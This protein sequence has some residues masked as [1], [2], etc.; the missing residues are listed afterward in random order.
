MKKTDNNVNIL[1][2][3]AFIGVIL[4]ALL[5]IF[6]LS[7]VRDL[8]SLGPTLEHLLNT[9]KNVCIMLVIGFTAYNFV[10]GKGKGWLIIYIIAMSIILIATILA[11][12]V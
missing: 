10:K 5:E 7:F 4:V 1:N 3:M 12:I 11:W 9:V 8:I 6:S 2:L